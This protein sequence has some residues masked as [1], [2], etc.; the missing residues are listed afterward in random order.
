MQD[1]GQTA[2]TRNQ[3]QVYPTDKLYSVKGEYSLLFQRVIKAISP[4]R[5]REHQ[6]IRATLSEVVGYPLTKSTFQNWRMGYGVPEPATVARLIGYFRARRS[7]TEWILAGL[8]AL[9]SR[10]QARRARRRVGFQRGQDREA[11]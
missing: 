6:G 3:K 10:Q 9:A 1:P 11:R 2:A 4:W 5:F 8:E 7:E